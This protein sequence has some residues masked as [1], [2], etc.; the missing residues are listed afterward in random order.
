M[1]PTP[2]R[3]DTV[4]LDQAQGVLLAGLMVIILAGGEGALTMGRDYEE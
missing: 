3:D 2:W 4:P 1:V